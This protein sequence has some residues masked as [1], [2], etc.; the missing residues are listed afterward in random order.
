MPPVEWKWVRLWAYPGNQRVPLAA[1]GHRR[2]HNGIL[3]MASLASTSSSAPQVVGALRG[4]YLH[5]G[6]FGLVA[7]CASPGHRHRRPSESRHPSSLRFHVSWRATCP[8]SSALTAGLLTVLRWQLSLRLPQAGFGVVLSIFSSIPGGRLLRWPAPP[9]AAVGQSRSPAPA[10]LVVSS[11]TRSPRP[12]FRL[13][14]LPEARPDWNL[15][16]QPGARNTCSLWRRAG[17]PDCRS[18]STGGQSQL[19]PSPRRRQSSRVAVR[20]SR[21]GGTLSRPLS[22]Q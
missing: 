4:E 22:G 15:A 11:A 13:A 1:N 17:L 20:P 18:L 3:L 2:H 7:V 10:M 12:A 8:S 9:R 14:R 5:R 19:G 16:A 6:E 21:L